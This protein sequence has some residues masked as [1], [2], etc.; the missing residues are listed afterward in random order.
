MSTGNYTIQQVCRTE[1]LKTGHSSHFVVVFFNKMTDMLDSIYEDL[2]QLT[3]S[4]QR[5]LCATQNN[6]NFD[7]LL[8]YTLDTLDLQ[9]IN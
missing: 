8:S 1:L 7:H 3:H 5:N 2:S 6:N 9:Q 4:P